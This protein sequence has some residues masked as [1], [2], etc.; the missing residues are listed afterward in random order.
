MTTTLKQ[1][2]EN[3]KGFVDQLKEDDKMA[4]AATRGGV[5]HQRGKV[6]QSTLSPAEKTE[7]HEIL[8][9]V[10]QTLDKLP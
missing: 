8:D 3:L 9:R 6:D 2:C 10:Q 1:E 4:I 5:S 7:C